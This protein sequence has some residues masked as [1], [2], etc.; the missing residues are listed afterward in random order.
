LML[1]ILLMAVSNNPKYLELAKN[2]LSNSCNS[3]HN[4]RPSLLILLADAQK[5]PL[6]INPAISLVFQPTLITASSTLRSSTG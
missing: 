1:Y 5:M 6:M 3:S 2:S 4:T